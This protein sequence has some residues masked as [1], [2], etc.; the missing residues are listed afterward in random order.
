MS[1]PQMLKFI[2]G[3][4]I[5]SVFVPCFAV[6]S[7]PPQMPMSELLSQLTSYAEQT[8]ADWHV[9]GM[10]IAVVQNGKTI[11]AQGFGE[12]NAEGAPVTPDTIFDIASL[13]KSFTA[14]LLA[15]QID[16]GKYSWDTK[17]LKLYP[18]F[19]LY[20][21]ETTQK[22]EVQDLLAHDSGLPEDATDV[23]GS[24]GYSIDHTIYALRFI[25]PV[26]PFRSE[27]AYEDIF[28][29]LAGEIIQKEG[30][31]SYAAILHQ[32][33]FFPLQMNDSYV[34]TEDKLYELSNV[35]QAFAYV[36]GQQYVY[37]MNPS[38]FV[39]LRA[40]QKDPGGS[41][42]IH[43][44]AAD[45]A[46]WL[47]FNMNNGLV[48]G[49]QIVS[50]ANM[51]F[52][53]SPHTLITSSTPEMQLNGETEK[54]YGEGWFID[55][56][57]YKPYTV[58]YHGGG[59]TGMH[60][61]MAYIPQEKIGIVILTNTW[62]NKVPEAIYQRFFDLYFNKQPLKDWNKIYLQSQAVDNTASQPDQCLA[63]K[64]ADLDQYV[65]TY[66]NPMFG[67]LVIS[68]EGNHLSLSIGPIGMKWRLTYCQNN[69]LQAYWPNPYGMNIPMLSSGQDLIHFAT[70]PNKKIQTM[71]IPSLND[72]GSGVFVKK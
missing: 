39:K 8:Q 72:N 2:V 25:K 21:P 50:A 9:P 58:L 51:N 60:A 4:L 35:A 23:L 56:Q 24:F 52:I 27:F 22:F 32:R 6:S 48:D 63:V 59:G 5:A 64:T 46:K 67:N 31:A 3:G 62:G 45:L 12:R 61:L 53:H 7:V 18:Q 68:K 29:M 69:V 13:T 54:A 47:I 41:G 40:L 33:L 44:S 17:V 28:P 57:E 14:T 19:K 34:D 70:S 66:Y 38:Y 55:A 43:S 16:E 36:S 65:G 15:M 26:A 30:S 71:T 49:H 42:G 20:D 11:Y 37:P 1:C 10:A